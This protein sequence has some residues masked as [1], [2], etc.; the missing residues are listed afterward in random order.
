M[1]GISRHP[2]MFSLAALITSLLVLFYVD[3]RNDDDLL[4]EQARIDANI[5]RAQCVVANDRN[6]VVV[7]AFFR[8]AEEF[9]DS[10]AETEFL[11]YIIRCLPQRDCEQPL[12]VPERPEE[13][14]SVTARAP[15]SG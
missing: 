3:D 7:S 2:A 1:K 15:D 9:P 14:D 11:D 8:L 5:L 12:A 6:N 10:D 13:C 4:R